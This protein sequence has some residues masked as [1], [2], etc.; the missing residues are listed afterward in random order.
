VDVEAREY[1]CSNCGAIFTSKAK[2]KKN[3]RH[4]CDDGKTG[5]GKLLDRSNPPE[6][7]LPED[8]PF[9]PPT[10]KA[11]EVEVVDGDAEFA[12]AEEIESDETFIDP[13]T[14]APAMAPV[15]DEPQKP[16]KKHKPTAKKDATQIEQLFKAFYAATGS[17]KL[18]PEEEMEIVAGLWAGVGEVHIDTGE[19]HVPAWMYIGTAGI[20]TALIM[21]RRQYSGMKA[22]QA[23]VK[24]PPEPKKKKDDISK[25]WDTGD[26]WQ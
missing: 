26:G 13:P 14:E 5:T 10:P 12:V 9:T 11:A 7:P 1:V 23:T 25:G 8:E 18:T 19:L 24:P 15:G 6:E 2:S 3:A 21:G 17:V 22:R 16:K 20:M 4:K